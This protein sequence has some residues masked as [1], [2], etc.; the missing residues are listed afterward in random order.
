MTIYK[1]FIEYI[2]FKKSR[3]H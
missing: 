3:I 1:L 2:I